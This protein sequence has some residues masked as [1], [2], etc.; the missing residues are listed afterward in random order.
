M[1]TLV[2]NATLISPGIVY[3]LLDVLHMFMYTVGHFNIHPD[4]K[5]EERESRNQWIV[6]TEVVCRSCTLDVNYPENMI[7]PLI[8]QTAL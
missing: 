5:K 4:N 8:I 2:L 6:R 3:W 7:C 1:K